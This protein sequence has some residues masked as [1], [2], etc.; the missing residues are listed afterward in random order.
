MV[1]EN[2]V[3]LMDRAM[4]VII[5]KELDTG[6]ESIS[7]KIVIGMRVPGTMASNPD[8]VSSI[9]VSMRSLEYGRRDNS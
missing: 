7:S 3:G 2:L 4:R 1:G 5:R 6:R 9:K 8:L